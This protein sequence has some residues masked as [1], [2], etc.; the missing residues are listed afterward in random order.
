MTETEERS[1]VA[2][3][4]A[5]R[6]ALKLVLAVYDDDAAALAAAGIGLDGDPGREPLPTALLTFIN[7]VV[8]EEI[9]RPRAAEII[10]LIDEHDTDCA[11]PDESGDDREAKCGICLQPPAAS[12]AQYDMAQITW[13]GVAVK[14]CSLCIHAQPV[15]ITDLHQAVHRAAPKAAGLPDF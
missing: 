8:P 15:S 10:A 3:S 1:I 4:G 2:E 14:V 6:D 7:N 5:M 13:D 11:A 12:G 9:G